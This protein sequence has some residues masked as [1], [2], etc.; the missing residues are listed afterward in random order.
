MKRLCETDVQPRELDVR[1]LQ[2]ALRAD[3]VDLNRSGDSQEGLQ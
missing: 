3:G 1:A 2:E